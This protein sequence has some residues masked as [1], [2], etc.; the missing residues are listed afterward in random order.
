MFGLA[1]SRTLYRRSRF[2]ITPIRR[3]LILT[4]WFNNYG[5]RVFVL[6]DISICLS[7]TSYYPSYSNL[8]GHHA[9]LT[10]KGCGPIP[11]VWISMS[12]SCKDL[13]MNV[14]RIVSHEV[15]L[16]EAFRWWSLCCVQPHFLY[17]LYRLIILPTFP[18]SCFC[19][20]TSYLDKSRQSFTPSYVI[21]RGGHANRARLSLGGSRMENFKSCMLVLGPR[22]NWI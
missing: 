9:K 14:L 18:L 2:T 22:R 8:I 10:P 12:L 17:W 19:K 13:R 7:S 21:W 6:S 4:F 11:C 1:L 3:S 16:A 5:A 20:A 15:S